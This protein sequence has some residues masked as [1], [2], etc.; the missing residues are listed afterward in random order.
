MADTSICDFEQLLL[1]L[2]DLADDAVWYIYYL[3][4]HLYFVI[5]SKLCVFYL[6]IF[7]HIGVFNRWIW[8]VSNKLWVSNHFIYTIF[9]LFLVLLEYICDWV[10]NPTLL[11]FIFREPERVLRVLCMLV[12]SVQL[13]DLRIHDHEIFV[14]QQIIKWILLFH[15]W[16]V[17]E[18]AEGIEKF[19]AAWMSFLLLII[20]YF[21][22]KISPRLLGGVT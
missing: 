2:L 6:V 15:F 16:E 1:A 7:L 20:I 11:F 12:A 13:Q 22:G 19:A 18:L 4:H 14:M 8:L 10:P 5:F 9:H 17:K 21:V 3:K